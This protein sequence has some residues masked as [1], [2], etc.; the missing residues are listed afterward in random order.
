MSTN[1]WQTLLNNPRMGAMQQELGRLVCA[2]VMPIVTELLSQPQ[3]TWLIL[4]FGVD[5]VQRMCNHWHMLWSANIAVCSMCSCNRR[6]RLRR[7]Q[8]QISCRTSASGSRP[9]CSPAWQ[10]STAWCR[11]LCLCC[12]LAP[13]IV[14][15]LCLMQ[16]QP[17][18]SAVQL[19]PSP[20]RSLP[21]PPQQLR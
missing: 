6:A 15:L 16:G 21:Q 14:L 17:R 7:L 10:P 5:D 2:S 8:P 9:H 19:H 1:A 11:Q 4:P 12:R 13:A 3:V 18:L 20:V